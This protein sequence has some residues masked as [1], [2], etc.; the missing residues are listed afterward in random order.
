MLI[1]T[2]LLSICLW[3]LISLSFWFGIRA[4]WP[5]A[6]LAAGAFVAASVSLSFVL[7][8]VPGGLGVFQGAAVLAAS[9]YGIPTEAALAFAIVTHGFQL[10]SVLVC[11]MIA[12]GR[13]GISI[14]AMIATPNAVLN[15]P[16]GAP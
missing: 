10:A 4:M 11:A 9:L 8:F 6:P 3:S 7:P 13:Q 5:S 16:V 15:S 14:K 12:A 2:I 1:R